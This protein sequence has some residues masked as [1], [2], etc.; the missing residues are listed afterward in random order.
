MADQP[1]KPPRSLRDDLAKTLDE[2]EWAWL[3]PH[4][5]RDAVI[6][7]SLQLDLLSVGEAVSRDEKARIQEWIDSGHLS[8]PTLEQIQAWTKEPQKKFLTLIVAPYVLAQEHL[9][10]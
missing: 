9:V 6:L 5:V 10:H 3:A 1:P 7:V 8:K 2:S 4:L